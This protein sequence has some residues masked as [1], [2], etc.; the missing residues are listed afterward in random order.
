MRGFGQL[1]FNPS[2]IND[3]GDDEGDDD[4]TDTNDDDNPFAMFGGGM[5]FN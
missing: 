3:D 4:D 1:N 2:F 5:P